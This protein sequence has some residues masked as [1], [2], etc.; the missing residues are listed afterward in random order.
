MS[1]FDDI[2]KSLIKLIEENQVFQ[3]FPKVEAVLYSLK[4]A[5]CT[6]PILGNST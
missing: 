1:G 2:A 3:P 5:L 4:Q 6:A